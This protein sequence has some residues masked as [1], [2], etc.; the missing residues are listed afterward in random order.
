MEAMYAWLLTFLL[1]VAPYG[2]CTEPACYETQP[3]YEQRIELTLDAALSVAYDIDEQPLFPGAWGREV[4][5]MHM[6]AVADHESGHFRKDVDDG[7]KRGDGGA[8]WCL[9]GVMVGKGLAEGH[10]G[11]QLVAD[12]RMCFSVGYHIM[13]LSLKQ[14]GR[15][16]HGLAV[17]ASGSCHLGR[18][19]AA[20]MMRQ[21]RSWFGLLKQGWNNDE[22]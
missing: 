8:S 15:N 2:T 6:L 17:Y 4:S 10:T 7:R 21:G 18:S 5:V 13:R 22:W 20:D 14:C 9:M 19:V 3:E 11:K 12:R 1:N 16:L